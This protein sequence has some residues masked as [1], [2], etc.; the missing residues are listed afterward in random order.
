VGE[1][2][3]IQWTDKTFNPW[4]GCA[5]VSPACVNCYADTWAKRR[6]FGGLWRRHGDR[7]LFGPSHWAEP[8]RWNREAKRRGLPFLVFCASMADVFEDHSALP[9]EREKLWELIDCTPWL[10]WQ[11]LTKRPENVMAMAPWGDDWPANVWV[12]TSVEDQTWADVRIPVLIEIPARIRFLSAEPL[13]GP[14]DLTAIRSEGWTLNVI[15]GGARDPR[16][17][18]FTGSRINWVIAGGESGGPD[19]RRLV[20]RD[21]QLYVPK[22]AALGWVRSLRDQCVSG[23]VAFF[24]KQ[25]GGPTPKSGGRELDSRTWDELPAA[26]VPSEVL[27]PT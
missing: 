26:W 11:L 24:L 13:L 25:W 15:A 5:R 14:V 18:P 23:E 6:G 17:K 19:R 8:E 10:T 27:Q 16:G 7:R 2:T 4:W 12:G 3:G 22:D 20:K 9:P 21:G 1:H